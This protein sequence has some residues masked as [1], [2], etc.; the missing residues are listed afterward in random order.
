[1]STRTLILL[2]WLQMNLWCDC[3]LSSFLSFYFKERRCTTKPFTQQ[4]SSSCRT[5]PALLNGNQP[6]R[7]FRSC[8]LR[9][10]SRD[11]CCPPL[12]LLLLL[13]PLPPLVEIKTPNQAMS[14]LRAWKPL[15]AM[16]VA[17]LHLKRQT[18]KCVCVCACVWVQSDWLH[19]KSVHERER[20]ES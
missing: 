6:T 14:A 3:F 18:F 10:R 12:D 11:A 19:V 1:M 17:A 8:C 2:I 7:E 20:R 13:L 5:A 16:T 4:Q 15:E 9:I